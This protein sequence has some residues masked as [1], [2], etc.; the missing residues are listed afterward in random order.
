MLLDSV[1]RRK[2]AGRFASLFSAV[3]VA[4]VVDKSASAR[5]SNNEDVRKLNEEGKPAE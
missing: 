4:S 5:T 3:G 1:T 2:F